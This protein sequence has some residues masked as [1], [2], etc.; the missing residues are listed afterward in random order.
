[1]LR[2]RLKQLST[3]NLKQQEQQEEDD[4]RTQSLRKQQKLNLQLLTLNEDSQ[5][6][7]NYF[8]QL[9][10]KI[11]TV[12]T[13]IENLQSQLQWANQFPS[14]IGLQSMKG[15]LP[16]PVKGVLIQH[17]GTVGKHPQALQNQSRGIILETPTKSVMQAV[18]LGEIVFVDQVQDYQHLVIVDHGQETF[19]VYGKL[20]DVFVTPGSFVDKGTPIGRV[21]EDPVTAKYHAYFELR[22]EGEAKDPLVWLKRGN[23]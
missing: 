20:Q 1:M 9:E 15:Q 8:M 10:A 12:S 13:E 17:F 22:I 6:R 16:I 23:Y 4:V 3:A 5:I 7:R 2:H 21:A 11:E 14:Q 19:S 18:A